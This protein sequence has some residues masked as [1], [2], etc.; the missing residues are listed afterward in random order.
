MGTNIE[1]TKENNTTHDKE[2]KNTSTI[3]H[4]VILIIWI[5]STSQTYRIDRYEKIRA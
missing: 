3:L 2:T 5:E 1:T 4:L